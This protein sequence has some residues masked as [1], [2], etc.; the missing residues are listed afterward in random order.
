MDTPS[1]LPLWL[2][3]AYTAF[4]ALLVPIYW[5][6]Y[7]PTNFL[8]FCDVA[9]FLTLAGIWMES[10]LLVAIV[11]VGVLGTQSL[12]VLDFAAQLVGTQITGMTAYMFEPERPLY[13]RG[14]S[15]FHGWLP[16][17]AFYLVWRLGYDRRAFWSWTFTAW[18]LILICYL[19][20]P[21]PSPDHGIKPVNINYVYGFSAEVPQTWMPERLWVLVEIIA[22][23]L[24]IYFPTHLLL[25]TS[26]FEREGAASVA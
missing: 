10:S 13:L 24:L 9:L 2:K 11:A 26:R 15:L 21:G 5:Y 19:L 14:L 8:Y 6:H 17:L 4:M 7:G 18:A 3:L 20:I 1:R 22:L 12:W 25:R 16:F 23:P